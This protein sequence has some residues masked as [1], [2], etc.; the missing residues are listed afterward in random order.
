MYEYIERQD[1]FGRRSF[2]RVKKIHRI[3]KK[4]SKYSLVTYWIFNLLIEIMCSNYKPF[5][6]ICYSFISL[7][8]EEY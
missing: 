3:V 2:V 4:S 5:V 1:Q 6:L 7:L 8:E